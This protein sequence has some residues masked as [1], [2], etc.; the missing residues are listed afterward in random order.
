MRGQ[1]TINLNGRT[2]DVVTG[3]PLEKSSPASSLKPAPS[4]TGVMINDI[5]P[6]KNHSKTTPKPT[7]PARASAPAKKLHSKAQRSRALVR[8]P[9]HK[10]HPSNS[11][12][13]PAQVMRSSKISKFAKDKDS[14][15]SSSSQPKRQY[16]RHHQAN[17]KQQASSHKNY[18]SHPSKSTAQKGS[19]V[20]MSSRAIKEQLINKQLANLPV[21]EPSKLTVP[22]REVDQ[23][24]TRSRRV[25]S[26]GAT[27]LALLLLGGYLTYLNMP[28]LS[29]RVAAAQAGIDATLPNYQPKGYEL[30]GPVA[31]SDGS[32]KLAYRANHDASKKYTV[33]QQASTWN[34]QAVLDNYVTEDSNNDYRINSIQGL[35]VYTYN[36]K[37][38]WVNG[39]ILYIIDGNT[40]LSAQQLDRIASSM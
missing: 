40:P 12:R 11:N 6:N 13:K 33:T 8:A 10:P 14:H 23:P 22:A 18:A 28:N 3:L 31:Y 19:P 2:Y 35:T 17:H 34:S 16:K 5:K 20:R 32:V 27:C 1:N 4:P 38:V 36:N 15:S 9:L 26:I 21:R 30:H 37:A 7:A 25:L 29:I 24:Q 39:G